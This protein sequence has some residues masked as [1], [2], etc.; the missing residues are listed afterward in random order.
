MI[1]LGGAVIAMPGTVDRRFAGVAAS[2]AD[3]RRWVRRVLDDNRVPDDVVD[4][5][6][7]LVSELATN[8]LSHT[9]SSRPGGW[10]GLRV[11]CDRVRRH[12]RVECDDAGNRTGTHPRYAMSGPDAAGGRGL[13]LVAALAT[14]YGDRADAT[15]R[16]VYFELH[17]PK[18]SGRPVPP[19]AR[20]GAP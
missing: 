20:R 19:P 14:A 16:T 3:A 10:F 4:T 5:A 9:C 17:W 1:G 6:L 7:L 8:A 18:S 15:G 12:V 11:A 2:V 13:A